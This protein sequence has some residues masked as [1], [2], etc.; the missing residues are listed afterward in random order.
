MSVSEAPVFIYLRPSQPVLSFLGNV[1]RTAWQHCDPYFSHGQLYVAC[2]R[3]GN[4]TNIYI[5]APEEKKRTSVTFQT[6]GNI[7]ISLYVFASLL[8][9]EQ[10]VQFI[11]NAAFF[12]VSCGP[13]LT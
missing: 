5:P 11:H 3:V 6:D 12:C 2:S 1:S 4:P 13:F 10:D 9:V 7:P 8:T